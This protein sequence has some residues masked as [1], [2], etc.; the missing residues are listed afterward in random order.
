[1][2]QGLV[3]KAASVSDAQEPQADLDVLMAGRSRFTVHFSKS[4]AAASL[5][6]FGEDELAER[7][8]H[9]GDQDLHLIR[10]I[11]AHYESPS[12][13][14]PVQGSRITHNH[15]TA[16]ATVTYFEGQARPLARSR[17]RPAKNRPPRFTPVPP[18]PDDGLPRAP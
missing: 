3:C 12:Y 8:L 18:R 9:M 13:P 4:Q 11:A 14:L 10:N 2:G 15:V 17:R 7:A 16:L 5:W 6:D 1:M